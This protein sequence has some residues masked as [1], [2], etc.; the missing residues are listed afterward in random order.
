MDCAA[1]GV[2][3]APGRCLSALFAGNAVCEEETLEEETKG[4]EEPRT[5]DYR[6]LKVFLML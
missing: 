2:L 3:P 4:G 1:A 5:W 6:L